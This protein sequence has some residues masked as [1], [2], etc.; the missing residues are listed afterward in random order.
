MKTVRS[1]LLVHNEPDAFRGLEETLREQQVLT[2]HAHD[3]AEARALLKDKSND[4]H[5]DLVLTDAVLPGGTWRDAIRLVGR[6]AA[7]TPVV[8]MSRIENMR[9]YLDTQDGGAADFI[10]PPLTGRELG[11]VL[12]LAVDRAAPPRIVGSRAPICRESSE[13]QF[14]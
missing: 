7:G 3:C 11:Y 14:A 1:V 13:Y 5:I 9:L 4:K 6:I 8:V 10:V 2:F 12:N